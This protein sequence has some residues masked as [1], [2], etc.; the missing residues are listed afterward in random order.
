VNGFT[1]LGHTFRLSNTT[2]YVRVGGRERIRW[3]IE[4][5]GPHGWRA[6]FAFRPT[7]IREARA[8]LRSRI[9]EANGIPQPCPLRELV[10]RLL[11]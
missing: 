2:T 4:C 5:E 11:A 6:G 1:Y 10:A 8:L 7:T 3:S 9:D